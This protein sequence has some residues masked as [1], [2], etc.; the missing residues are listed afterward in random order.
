VRHFVALEG[1]ADGWLSYEGE[2]AR[3]SGEFTVAQVITVCEPRPEHGRLAPAER[4]RIKARQGVELI[5]S[6]DPRR[7][8]QRRGRSA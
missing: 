2:L 5:T 3:E 7:R 1:A 6:G 4:F 8:P